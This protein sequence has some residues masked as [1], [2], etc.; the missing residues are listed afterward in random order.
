MK[1]WV[2]GFAILFAA[3]GLCGCA[4]TSGPV[5]YS[6]PGGRFSFTAPKGWRLSRDTGGAVEIV[7]LTKGDDS[8]AVGF[9]RYDNGAY[10]SEEYKDKVR[11]GIPSAMRRERGT[12]IFSVSEDAAIVDGV[13]AWVYSYKTPARY[14]KTTMVI[15]IKNGTMYNITVSSEK[16]MKD[17]LAAFLESFKVA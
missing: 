2:C 3:L 6:D 4:D 17:L 10:L 16:E 12:A 15:F 11:A 9:K 8:I 14:V 7:T 1:R 5:V 13:P